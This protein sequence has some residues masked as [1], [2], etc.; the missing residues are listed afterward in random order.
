MFLLLLH[1]SLLV[2]GNT[3]PVTENYFG[4]AEGAGEPL[5]GIQFPAPVTS[6]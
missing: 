2:R 1:L 4:F 3:D 5:F 6:L